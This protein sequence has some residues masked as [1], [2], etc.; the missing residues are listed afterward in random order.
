MRQEELKQRKNKIIQLLNGDISEDEDD[1]NREYDEEREEE[2]IEDQ[3][4]DQDEIL[5][6]SPDDPHQESTQLFKERMNVGQLHAELSGVQVIDHEGE[7]LEAVDIIVPKKKGIK[8][9]E[10]NEF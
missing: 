3:D 10:Q 7:D 4:F 1:E 2:E 8:R 6:E 5:G 9:D